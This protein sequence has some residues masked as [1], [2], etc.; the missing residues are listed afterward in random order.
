M[1]YRLLMLTVLSLVVLDSGIVFPRHASAAPAH[2]QMAASPAC[3]G[4]GCDGFDPYATRCAGSGAS[5]RVVDSVP[6]EDIFAA[7]VGYL[8]LWYSDTCGTNWSRYV[9][10][11]S[12]SNCPTVFDLELIEESSPGCQC[13]LGIQFVRDDGQAPNVR[14][15]QQY[16]PHTRAAANLRV[17]CSTHVNAN[18]LLA[19]PQFK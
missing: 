14:T 4:D 3:A 15:T 2:F 16:L 12:A 10:T 9:C 7:R 19:H 17:D 5:Y 8:Q 18:G 6:A 1:K 11:V 13:G